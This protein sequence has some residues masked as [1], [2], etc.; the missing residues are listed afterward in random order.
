M[1]DVELRAIPAPRMTLHKH[2]GIWCAERAIIGGEIH[3]HVP[4]VFADHAT[5]GD[6]DAY[7]RDRGWYVELRWA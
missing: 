3:A 6:V 4:T 5:F 7:Y 1:P 2:D